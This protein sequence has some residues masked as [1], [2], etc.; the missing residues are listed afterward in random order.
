M[1]SIDNP[2]V[3]FGADTNPR[4]DTVV[5]TDATNTYIHLPSW[6]GIDI[7][8]LMVYQNQIISVCT[9]T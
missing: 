9:S 8:F 1:S 3:P 6:S 7:D 2:E 4:A 5:V